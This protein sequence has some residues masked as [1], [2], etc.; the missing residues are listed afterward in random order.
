[1]YSLLQFPNEEKNSNFF[2]IFFEVSGESHSAEKS[3]RG[4]LEIFEHPFCCKREKIEGGTLWRN[5]KNLQ[6][7]VSR[8]RNNKQKIFGHGRDS[9]PR[10][11]A[12]QTSNNPK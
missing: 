2:S 4:P 7:K 12:W 10:P 3:K 8:S 11:S 1:M 5:L 9:I 6:K